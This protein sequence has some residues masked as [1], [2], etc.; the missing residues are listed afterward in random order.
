MELAH[1]GT[2][3]ALFSAAEE[4]PG[5]AV[6]LVLIAIPSHWLYRA[7]HQVGAFGFQDYRGGDYVPDVFGDNVGGEEIDFVAGVALSSLVG[8][9][10]AEVAVAEAVAG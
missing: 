1:D 4:L 6:A 9:E 7:E 8:L 3:G 2:L 5:F 10:A